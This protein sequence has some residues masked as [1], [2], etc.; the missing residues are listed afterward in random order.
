[1][2][3]KNASAVERLS[4]VVNNSLPLERTNNRNYE[5]TFIK[6]IISRS[7]KLEKLWF[8]CATIS[9][10][11][12]TNKP[13]NETINLLRILIFR[14]QLYFVTLFSQCFYIRSVQLELCIDENEPRRG[15]ESSAQKRF[16]FFPLR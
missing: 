5:I 7:E 12:E 4:R 14:F 2:Q 13:E 9:S 3:I 6:K 16:F 10:C 15:G 11:G 8:T 1:M